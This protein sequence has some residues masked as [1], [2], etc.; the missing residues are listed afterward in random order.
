MD[1]FVLDSAIKGKY[2]A[3]L[4]FTEVNFTPAKYKS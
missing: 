4:I 2:D 1:A 3:I